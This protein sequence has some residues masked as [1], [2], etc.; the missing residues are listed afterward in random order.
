MDAD[1]PSADPL[2]WDPLVEPGR[3]LFDRYRLL[4]KIGEGGMGEVWRV[5]HVNLEAERALKLIKPELAQNDKGW[6]RFQREARLMAKINHPNAVAVYDFGRTQSV[7]YIEMEFVRGRSLTDVLKDNRDKPMPLDWTAQ[8]LDQLCAV[9][10]EAHG[11]IDEKTG[12][13]RPI[14]HRDLKPSNLMLV[15]RKGDTG[16]PRLKVLDFGIAK[17]AE[18]EGSPELTGAGDLVGTPAFMSPEQI[19]GGFEKDGNTHDIDGRSDL[20]S[21]GV[22]LYQLLTGALPFRGSKMALL[23]AHLNNAPMPMKEA[24]PKAGV[25]PEVERVV[26]RCLEKDPAKRPQTARELAE[27]FRRVVGV[28]PSVPR[29]RVS[30][31]SG[32]AGS[33][34]GMAGAVLALPFAAVALVPSL[35][36]RLRGRLHRTEAP[37]PLDRRANAGPAS[38]T[39]TPTKP[40][41]PASK[42]SYKWGRAGEVPPTDPAAGSRVE[43]P[44]LL[45]QIIAESR[46]ESGRVDAMLMPMVV[47]DPVVGLSRIDVA[48]RA[49]DAKIDATD[50]PSLVHELAV[51]RGRLRDL[52]TKVEGSEPLEAM[53]E[54]FRADLDTTDALRHPELIQPRTILRHTDVSFPAT[55][56]ARKL[57]NL[58]VQLVPAAE[59]LPSGEVREQPRPHAHDTTLNLLLTPPTKPDTPWPPVKVAISVAA[60]NFEIEGPGRAEIVVPLSGKTPAVQFGLRGLDVGLGRIMVDFAQDGRPAGSVDLAPEVVADHDPRRIARG[61]APVVGEMNLSLGLG[62]D[63]ATPDVVLKVF[64]HRLAGHSGRLQFVLSSTHHALAD[65]P[66]LDGDLGTLDIKADVA[67]WVGAQL[68]SVGALAEHLDT[69]PEDVTRTLGAVG[70]NLFQQLLPPALSRTSA[71]LSASAESRR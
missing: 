25:P 59:T 29:R 30:G 57:Y 19:R 24:N 18:D 27:D 15:E 65:L 36:H 45:D 49:I 48:I 42:S 34:L 1:S 22:V 39:D 2:Y 6:R 14:I 9:L 17:I 55:V 66:V 35:L 7:G 71:G 50:S 52:R 62:V 21:T 38:R 40:P 68:Q 13:P 28:G 61:S 31:A 46:K 44:D 64:E 4:E 56:R 26:L 58:R 60:E 53:L 43:P 16:P 5:W 3:V 37:K 51:A 67:A 54:K 10:Q 12:Q 41:A 69:T 32:M 70:C 47:A 33:V 20:Y 11:H 23:A 63:L 8:V